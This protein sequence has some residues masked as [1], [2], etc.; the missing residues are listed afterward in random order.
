MIMQSDDIF[1]I[2]IYSNSVFVQVNIFLERRKEIFHSN[3]KQLVI[4]FLIM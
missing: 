3:G 2:R 1:F 4:D